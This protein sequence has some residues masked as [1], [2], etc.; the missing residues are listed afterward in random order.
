[1]SSTTTAHRRLAFGGLIAFAVAAALALGATTPAYAE[2]DIPDPGSRPQPGGPGGN[3]PTL[4]TTPG[5]GPQIPGTPGGPPAVN[6]P[7][8]RVIGP[9]ASKILAEQQAVEFL[10][11]RLKDATTQLTVMR[12]LYKSAKSASATAEKVMARAETASADSVS[13]AYRE[14][15]GVPED[16]SEFAPGLEHLAPGLRDKSTVESRSDVETYRLATSL[17]KDARKALRE[18]QKAYKELLAQ[19]EK[20][21]AEFAKRSKGLQSLMLQNSDALQKARDAADKYAGKIGF[22]PGAGIDGLQAS[23]KALKA[24][25]YALA[26]L[27]KPYVW[28][29]EGPNT[30]DCSGLVWAAYKYAGVNVGGRTARQQYY[31]T[32]KVRANQMLPGDLVFFGPRQ[33]DPESIHHVGIYIGK[34]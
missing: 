19:V 25:R 34:G 30:F 16:M 23:P 5:A 2:P 24:V 4:P 28:G 8:E 6:P 18:A 21:Q 31:A 15:A 13:K 32:P 7:G 14:Q 9:M 3:I 22:D 33:T 11:E 1:M 10:G 27:G 12:K 20:L 17:A 29:D 26:Q